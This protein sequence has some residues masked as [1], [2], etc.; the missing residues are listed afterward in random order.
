MSEALMT[1][2]ARGIVEPEPAGV[3]RG[4]R[5]RVVSVDVGVVCAFVVVGYGC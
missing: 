5:S 1:L 3:K 2:K 4:E